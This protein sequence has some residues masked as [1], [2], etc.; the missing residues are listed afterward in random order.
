MSKKSVN[1]TNS[2]VAE[3]ESLAEKL[4]VVGIAILGLAPSIQQFSEITSGALP[5]AGIFLFISIGSYV[6]RIG[7]IMVGFFLMSVDPENRHIQNLKLKFA[8]ITVGAFCVSVVT[9]AVSFV[10]M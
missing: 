1:A 9:L 10:I 2:Q 4:F 5:F 7:V 8:L 3:I 6:V